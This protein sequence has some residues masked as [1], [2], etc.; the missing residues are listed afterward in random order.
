MDTTFL[1]DQF[2]GK[3]SFHGGI[4]IQEVLPNGT[5]KDIENEV[6]RRIAIYAPGGGYVICA[7]HCIQDDISP[8]NVVALYKSAEK[9]GTY[10]LNDKL[11]KL[12]EH[13]PP[14]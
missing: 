11:Y 1:K 13:I 10:P 2:G 4:D 3:I 7:A 5:I 6:K 12:R 14:Q 8:E 9:W